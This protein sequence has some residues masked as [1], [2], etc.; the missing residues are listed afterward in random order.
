MSLKEQIVEV[1]D[2]V[3]KSNLPASDYV[4][5]PYIGCPHGCKYCYAC[6]MRRFTK[7]KEE[8]GTFIDIKQCSKPIN[9]KRL[10]GKTVF[11][12]SVTDCYNQYEEKYCITKSILNQ[13]ISV[14]CTI[15]ISTK[16][17]LILRDID[18]LK[19][20]NNLKVCISINTLN[21]KF[22][23][24]MDNASSIANRLKALKVLHENGIYVVLFMSPIFPELTDFREI[25]KASCS[26]V[27]E[28][29]FENLNLRGSYKEK[30][31]DYIGKKYPQ[32]LELYKQIYIFGKKYYFNK[33]IDEI[34]QYCNE[35]SIK[36]VNY[37]YHEKLVEKNKN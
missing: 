15:N 4:I 37:F 22:K 19:K 3:T 9:K 29:W 1:K 8:W 36:Y 11:L 28:Y 5:N 18:I 27:D 12:S 2:Y 17:D 23:N 7:H 24:D 30:I 20:L 13:L 14:D 31:L 21:E 35:N 6:F 26:F 34:E 16:S 25:I 33:L 10:E 32:H